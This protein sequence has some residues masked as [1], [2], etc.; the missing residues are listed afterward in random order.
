MKNI[1]IHYILSLVILA[2]I[3][4][5]FH[6]MH[7]FPDVANQMDHRW[8][9]IAENLYNHGA[10]S[11]GD[12]DVNGTLIPTVA[13]PPFLPIIYY[14]SFSLFGLERSA[15]E[16]VRFI[17]ICLNI[18]TIFITYQIGRLFTPKIGLIAA[19]FAATDLTA[20]YHANNYESPDTL[21]TFFTALSVLYLVRFVKIKNCPKNIFLAALFLGLAS[22]TKVAIY[23]LWLPLLVLLII[24]LLARRKE[25][26]SNIKAYSIVA[27]FITVT[28]LCLG[29]WKIRNYITTGYSGFTAQN[30]EAM[31]W[32]AAYLRA[33]Q[34]GISFGESLEK[35][36]E[37]TNPPA[38]LLEGEKSLY[39]VAI[40]KNIIL[41]SPVDY[42]IVVL[43]QDLKLLLG[44]PPP[45]FLLSKSLNE[46]IMKINS[47]LINYG[48]I[49]KIRYFINNGFSP[50]FMLWGGIKIHLI[51]VY[52]L[53]LLALYIIFYK[54][55]DHS[56]YWATAFMLLYVVYFLLVTSPCSQDRY[57]LPVMPICYVL[58]SLAAAYLVSL[59]SWNVATMPHQSTND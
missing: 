58:S 21:L 2:H 33:Y 8:T 1:S 51:T 19:I 34:E 59:T 35:M 23:L 57:R 32:N 31:V 49:K 46:D 18:G 30:G 4:M 20:F 56:N 27:I 22:L 7:N 44:S 43:R 12:I 40:A 26:D 5:Y 6:I 39:K 16:F 24:Y 10:Y 47:E 15:Y 54:G 28:A 3:M 52:L 48:T 50:V 41:K 25:I 11:R 17:F 36:E 9:D 53:S 45:Y 13:A 14:I 38:N 37:L 29:G 42:L 55:S